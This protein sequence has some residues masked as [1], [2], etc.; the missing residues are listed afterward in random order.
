MKQ[1]DWYLWQEEMQKCVPIS[2]NKVITKTKIE[3][4]DKLNE[5]KSTEFKT[6]YDEINS[7]KINTNFHLKKNITLGL[8]ANSDK[9][10]RTGN[11]PIDLILDFHGLT[12]DQ[13]FDSLIYNIENA[14]NRGLRCLLVITGKGNRT[15]AGKTSIK[16]S[17]EKW[18]KIEKISNKIIKYID[19]DVK[20]GG[21]GSLYILLKKH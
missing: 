4:K 5:N 15:P 14:Y 7:P 19:A 8:D 11:Y 3:I 18:L 13:A 9:K 21:T 6:N 20:H 16:D 12:L 2:S 10:L 17:I 1:E